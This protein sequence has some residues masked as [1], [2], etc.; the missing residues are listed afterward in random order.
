MHGTLVCCIGQKV[1]RKRAM[2]AGASFLAYSSVACCCAVLCCAVLCCAVL[3]KLIAMS[4]GALHLLSCL[5]EFG[6]SRH[7]MLLAGIVPALLRLAERTHDNHTCASATSLLRLLTNSTDRRSTE[8]IHGGGLN[9]AGNFGAT[10]SFAS[11]HQTSIGGQ[12]TQRH[13]GR[14][15]QAFFQL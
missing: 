13:A 8:G 9:V 7:S 3:Y 6:D 14:P 5:A 4:A 12:G 1:A 11:R 15:F 10:N 2:Q